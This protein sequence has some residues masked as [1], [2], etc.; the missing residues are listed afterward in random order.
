MKPEAYLKASLDALNTFG[1]TEDVDTIYAACDLIEASFRAGGKLLIAGNGGSAADAQ[2]IAAE[3][4]GR[5]RHPH[6]KP[7]PAIA[8]TTD[9]SILTA[10]SNDFSFDTVFSRQVQ[11]LGRAGDVLW[12]ISTSG[13]SRNIVIA[14]DMALALDMKT[15]GFCCDYPSPLHKSDVCLM[16]TALRH[17]AIIQQLH[18]VAAHAICGELDDRFHRGQ[19]KVDYTT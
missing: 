10:V 7:L 4:V 2:H 6:R 9:T 16:P 17:T 8:L 19:S 12:L 5:F 11:A 1:T 18:M 3:F 13:R 14:A 15:I